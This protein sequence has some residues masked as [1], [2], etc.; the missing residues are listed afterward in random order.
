MIKFEGNV[1][2]GNKAG[3]LEITIPRPKANKEGL[4]EGD[5]ILVWIKRKEESNPPT[6]RNW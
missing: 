6:K 4:I 5:E 1:R 3:V 2:K